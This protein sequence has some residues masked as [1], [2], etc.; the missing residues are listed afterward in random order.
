MTGPL[1][2]IREFLGDADAYRDELYNNATADRGIAARGRVVLS[3]FQ[4][5]AAYV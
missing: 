3:F 4:A 1:R 5:V 2:D